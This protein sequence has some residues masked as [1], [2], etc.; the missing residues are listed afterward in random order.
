MV[1]ILKI[2]TLSIKHQFLDFGHSLIIINFLHFKVVPFCLHKIILFAP[3]YKLEN[4]F[5]ILNIKRNKFIIFKIL[6]TNN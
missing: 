2:I 5:K 3:Y 6:P 1:K 4:Q